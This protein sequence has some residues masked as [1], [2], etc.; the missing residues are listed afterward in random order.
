[1]WEI[2]NEPQIKICSLSNEQFSEY[3]KDLQKEVKEER[4]KRNQKYSLS[5]ILCSVLLGIMSGR[6]NRVSLYRYLKN[7]FTYLE[8]L[9]G[10]KEVGL[11]SLR[12]FL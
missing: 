5:F 10:Y 9:T 8:Q 1:M 4:S 6:K 12:Q 7:R 2:K 11:I 3:F